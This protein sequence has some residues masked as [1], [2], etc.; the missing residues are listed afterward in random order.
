M[1]ECHRCGNAG[2]TGFSLQQALP[3]QSAIKGDTRSGF[4]LLALLRSAKD[5]GGGG[6]RGGGGRIGSLQFTEA[7][8]LL[9]QL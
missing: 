7:C 6:V 2:V 4:R 5:G 8:P 1:S 3:V 9:L